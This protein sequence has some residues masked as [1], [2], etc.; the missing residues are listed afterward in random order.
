[1]AERYLGHSPL[2]TDAPHFL[3]HLH[4][5]KTGRENNHPVETHLRGVIAASESRERLTE[6]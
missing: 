2:L 3:E 5:R 4:G 6:E 1:M